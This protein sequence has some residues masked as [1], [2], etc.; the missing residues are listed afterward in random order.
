LPV[1]EDARKAIRLS[2]DTFDGRKM[3][4]RRHRQ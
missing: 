3:M 1:L 4:K 2:R